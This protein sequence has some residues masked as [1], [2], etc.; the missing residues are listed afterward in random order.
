M[1]TLTLGYVFLGAALCTPALAQRVAQ[2]N[3]AALDR[4]VAATI[5]AIRSDN[6]RALGAMA[7]T[8]KGL[9]IYYLYP[10]NRHP[11][12]PAAW[13]S[14]LASRKS[15]TW[16]KAMP[17]DGGMRPAI[18]MTLPE[19]LQGIAR[20]DWRRPTK[21]SYDRGE[22]VVYRTLVPQ[23]LKRRHPGVRFVDLMKMSPENEFQNALILGFSRIGGRGGYRLSVIG[24]DQWKD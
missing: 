8:R 12:T 19:F 23:G 3:R 5:A 10:D 13:R 4:A 14:A 2:S 7:D 11:F 6:W 20:V 16:V 24:V 22:E 21:R 15:I 9:T 17:G 18:R 1:R